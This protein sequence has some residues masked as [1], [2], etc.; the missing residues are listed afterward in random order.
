MR[1]V[2]GLD[3]AVW[4]WALVAACV[5]LTLLLTGAAASVRRAG[6][7]IRDLETASVNARVERDRLDAQL[8]RERAA[9]EALSLELTRQRSRQSSVPS[10]VPTVTLEPSG[11]RRASPPAGTVTAVAPEQVVLIRLVL[12]AKSVR[13]GRVYEIAARD[14]S[15][16]QVRWVRRGLAAVEVDRNL[17]VVA[18]VTGEM[19]APGSYEFHVSVA[20]SASASSETAS[21][22]LTIAGGRV[23]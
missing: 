23:P 14:W 18:N 7:R 1:G 11:T 3:R 22:E 4:Q 10:S 6:A 12:P 2:K 19:L 15:S 13:D 9:R 21:Y 20:G 16:G 17:A 5:L 8:M